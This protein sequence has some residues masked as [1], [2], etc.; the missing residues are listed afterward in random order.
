MAR[1]ALSAESQTAQPAGLPVTT[2]F[3]GY[4]ATV[5][6]GASA[7]FKLRRVLLGVRAGASVPTS[8]QMTV[9]L[10]RQ[11]VAV[12]GTGFTL[13]AGAALDP[14]SAASAIGGL[15]ITTAATAGTTGPTLAANALHKFSFNTQSMLDIP[16]ELLE[17]WIVDQGTANG[18]AFVNI[19]NALP[20][21]HLFT[22]SAEWE[23]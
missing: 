3:N 6:A 2:T 12:A 9:A 20:A 22:I 17:E 1:F 7:N 5:M 18:L 10:Y 15:G 21:A 8:Q 16:A 13:T 19:G 23:E 4:F 11:T 14:R